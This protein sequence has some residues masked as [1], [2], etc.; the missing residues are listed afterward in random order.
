[1]PTLTITT[2][3]GQAQRIGI[4]FGRLNNRQNP[5]RT[6]RNATADEVKADVIE[7][8]RSTVI[9]YEQDVAAQAASRG[10]RDIDLT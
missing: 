6:P 8:L 10:V 9:N 5:D 4:A 7:F 2:N 1:M 3:A